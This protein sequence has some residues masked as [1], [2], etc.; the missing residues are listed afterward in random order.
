MVFLKKDTVCMYPGDNSTDPVDQR[1]LL[2]AL[3]FRKQSYFIERNVTDIMGTG[4]KL[5][6]FWAPLDKGKDG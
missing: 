2:Q 3:K 4:E 5:T 1:Q 6:N